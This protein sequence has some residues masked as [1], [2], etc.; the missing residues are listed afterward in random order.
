MLTTFLLFKF[1]FKELLRIVNLGHVVHFAINLWQGSGDTNRS[2]C[3]RSQPPNYIL[4]Y[5]REVNLNC[6]TWDQIGFIVVL[7]LQ[8]LQPGM[9]F[10][11]SP[12]LNRE[13]QHAIVHIVMAKLWQI[14]TLN[15]HGVSFHKIEPATPFPI[16][17]HV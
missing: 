6:T 11:N 12:F 16:H 1:L 4:I 3:C 14:K 15:N 10:P 17:R 5:L 13:L 9:C 7:N 8:I 2:E